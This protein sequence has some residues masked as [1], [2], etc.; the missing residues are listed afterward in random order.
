MIAELFQVAQRLADL[1]E[2][3]CAGKGK[4][5]CRAPH[6]C[7]SPTHCEDAE[8][9]FTKTLRMKFPRT[10]H[11]THP[12][13]GPN[14]CT[15][16]PAARPVCTVHVCKVN[17]MGCLS[18]ERVND[19]Y[20]DLRENLNELLGELKYRCKKCDL[21]MNAWGENQYVMLRDEV[22]AEACSGDEYILLCRNCIEANLGRGLAVEDLM[23]L[24]MNDKIREEILNAFQP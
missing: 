3:M 17:S 24:P 18:V 8:E 9:F 1:T 5:G 19:K 12:F 6:S 23:A 2:P 10:D 20:F 22:W 4:D 15:L 13:M 7:C 21:G 16:P 11:L 14:G